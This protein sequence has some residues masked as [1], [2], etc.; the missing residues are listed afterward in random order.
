MDVG[1]FA[2]LRVGR[3]VSQVEGKGLERGSDT[4]NVWPS[5][6]DTPTSPSCSGFVSHDVEHAILIII[7]IY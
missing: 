5:G 2:G 1:R 6:V 4:D 3:R 7:A